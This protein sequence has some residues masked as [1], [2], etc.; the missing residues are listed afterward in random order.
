VILTAMWDKKRFPDHRDYGGPG[1]GLFRST[2]GGES[3]TRIGAPLPAESTEP[4]RIGVVFSE[5]DPNRAYAISNT[6]SGAHTG[7]YRSDDMGATWTRISTGDGSLQS[8]SGGFA[9][10]FGR[11]WVDPDNADHVFSAGVNMLESTN[12][13][14]TWS[15][16]FTLHADQHAIDWDPVVED[17]AYI[18]NDGGF[19]RSDQNGLVVGAFSRPAAQP[20]MQFYTIDVSS[21]DSS[22]VSG[23]TQDNGSLRT[24]GVGETDW[25][26]YRG[27]DGMMNRIA[28]DDQKPGLCLLAERL[29]PA[30]LQRRREQLQHGHLPRGQLAVQLGVPA[31]DRRRR[32]EHGLLRRQHPEALRRRRRNLAGGQ[33]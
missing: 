13:G 24:W 28:P 16:S 23:G 11:L 3:W 18:G 9:W 17:R 30:Q 25:N 20:W 12:A 10:W 31:R 32:T 8:Q 4:G 19:Y 27:G 7:F 29:L 5:S 21:Q 14:A 6:G 15:R 2:D 33:R 26:N 1:S 22:R